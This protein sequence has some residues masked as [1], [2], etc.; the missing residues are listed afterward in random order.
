MLFADPGQ[1]VVSFSVRDEAACGP[2]S[3]QVTVEVVAQTTQKVQL[4][5]SAHYG[6]KV[7]VDSYGRSL[8]L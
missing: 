8:P 7:E 3:A 5:S 2:A 4:G 6:L 1:R